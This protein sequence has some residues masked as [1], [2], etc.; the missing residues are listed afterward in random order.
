MDRFY[1]L[2][3]RSVIFQGILVILMAFTVCYMVI[4]QREVPKEL[5][6]SF[7]V[8]VGY[9]FGGKGQVNAA[10]EVRKYLHAIGLERRAEAAGD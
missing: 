8:V 7:G 2:L 6:L 5:W 4:A 3:E 9:F 10:T 1:E